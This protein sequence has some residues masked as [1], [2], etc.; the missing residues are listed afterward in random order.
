MIS[1]NTD[2]TLDNIC[3]RVTSIIYWRLGHSDNK[4]TEKNFVI[5]FLSESVVKPISGSGLAS[6]NTERFRLKTRR[7]DKGGG[8]YFGP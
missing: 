6:L 8:L 4:I 7:D 3:Y 5:I 1:D 2:N